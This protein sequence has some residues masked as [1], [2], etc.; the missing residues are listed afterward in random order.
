MWACHNRWTITFSPKR[1][2]CSNE[3]D[4]SN[5]GTILV[6]L[7]RLVNYYDWT[8]LSWWFNRLWNENAAIRIVQSALHCHYPLWWLFLKSVCILIRINCRLSRRRKI[9]VYTALM[10][11]HCK[12]LTSRRLTDFVMVSARALVPLVSFGKMS[13]Q[14]YQGI[15]WRW[16]IFNSRLT[17]KHVVKMPRTCVKTISTKKQRNE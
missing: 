5:I 3:M 15:V 11:F 10:H 14:K 4:S 13:V 16:L 6:F 17:I 12:H 8:S 9:V 1:I 2:T 7:F